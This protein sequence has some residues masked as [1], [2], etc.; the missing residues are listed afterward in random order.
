MTSVL[1]AKLFCQML[2]ED[3]VPKADMAPTK[4]VAHDRKYSFTPPL[5]FLFWV[6]SSV[7]F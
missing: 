7:S 1:D 6:H 5:L 2:G 4:V 3:P